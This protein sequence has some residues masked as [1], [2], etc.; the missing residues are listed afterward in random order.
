M[1]LLDQPFVGLDPAGRDELTEIIGRLIEKGQQLILFTSA[2]AMPEFITH[3]GVLKEGTLISYTREAYHSHSSNM[4]APETD[5]R[6][7]SRLFSP[8]PVSFSTAVKMVNVTVRYEQKQ[9]L[10]NLNWQVNAGEQWSVSGPNGSGKSTLLSL[11]TA[12]NPQ[13]YANGDLSSAKEGDRE[14]AFGT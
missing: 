4:A 7:V 9:V 6:A 5:T 12:D 13:A 1:L 8:S 3:V 2:H 11:I 10:T 14:K